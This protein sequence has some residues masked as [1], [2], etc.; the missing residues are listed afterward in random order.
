MFD[1]LKGVYDKSETECDIAISF[2][3]SVGGT[4]QNPCRDLLIAY[5]NGP[6][7]LR[8]QKIAERLASTTTHRSR[9]GLLFLVA[10]MEGL[11][12][13]VIISRFPADSGILAEQS[14]TG[15]NISFLERIFMK[16]AKSYKAVVYRHRSLTTGFWSG[17]AV[18]KQINSSEA[19][20]SDYWIAEFLDSDFLTTSAAGTRRLAIAL[21]NAARATSD[22][23]LKNEIVAA[24]TLATGLKGQ[25]LSIRDFASRIGLSAGA[26]AAL[27][28]EVKP[29][30]LDEK[31]QLS[32]DEFSK[33]VAYRSVELDSGGMLMAET[34]KFDKIFE[35]EAVSGDKT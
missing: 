20:S 3:Q 5:K 22:L 18:D 7:Q 11:D 34:D 23:A 4:Q 17:H 6:T 12:H 27:F 30:A 26:K 35:K 1:L 10:G 31:F 33:Q 13:K 2:N 19:D 32:A 16:N 24:A 8:G 9:L 21:R 28:A 14:A 15:L 29:V 25:R